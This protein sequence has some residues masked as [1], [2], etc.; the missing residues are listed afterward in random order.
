LA[1]GALLLVL[2]ACALAVRAATVTWTDTTLGGDSWHDAANWSSAPLLPQPADTAAL[3][4]GG[5]AVAA[6]DVTITNLQLRSGSTLRVEGG[7]FFVTQTGHDTVFIAD[8]GGTSSVEVTGGTLRFQ[9]GAMSW[10]RS[11]GNFRG[12]FSGGVFEHLDSDGAGPLY[13]DLRLA[14]SNGSTCDIE[15]SGTA[16]WNMGAVSIGYHTVVP[17]PSVF[18]IKDQAV[19]NAT[20]LLVGD[21]TDFT[22]QG[23]TLALSGQNG[24]MVGGAAP[25][26]SDFVMTG[27][28]L[29]C[30]RLNVSDAA[31]V[32]LN[33]GSTTISEAIIINGTAAAQVEVRGGT[34]SAKGWQLGLSTAGNTGTL[35][36]TNGATL[37][38]PSGSLLYTGRWGRGEVLLGDAAGAGH[39]AAS[40]AVY[41]DDEN[42]GGTGLIRGWGTLAVSSINWRGSNTSQV[43][44]DGY[45][46]DRTLAVTTSSAPVQ[47]YENTG[48]SGWRAINRGKLTLPG[49]T[50]RSSSGNGYSWGETAGD[51]VPDLLNSARFTFAGLGTGPGTLTGA[52]LA[53]DRTDIPALAGVHHIA[54][55]WEFTLVDNTFTSFDLV[56]RYDPL[57]AGA[58]WEPYL[59]LF[60]YTGGAWTDITAAID[61]AN[62]LISA[63]G[64][65]GFS[66]FAVAPVPEPALLP[67]ALLLLAG[68]A[69]RRARRHAHAITPTSAPLPRRSPDQTRALA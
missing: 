47:T 49:I 34:V 1:P 23:G 53:G 68:A 29:T 39:V 16:Q 44:A 54:N 65:T 32:T 56:L 22:L 60:H 48:D 45:G 15:L 62:K 5:T 18:T 25:N 42:R 52:L 38:M 43:V 35:K 24:L 28:A 69:R 8:S 67:G 7:T 33:G 37:T 6:A 19:L 66:L 26:Q 9:A 59:R 2:V 41:F 20:T 13:P 12:R 27:G 14:N 10:G 36:I 61:P 63:S 55:A 31:T 4:N 40:G 51:T 21:N 58:V 50:V 30:N 3:T 11:T 64:L 57:A 17:G 46:A